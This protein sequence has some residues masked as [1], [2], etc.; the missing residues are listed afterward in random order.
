MAPVPANREAHFLTLP[1]PRPT[2]RPVFQEHHATHSQAVTMTTATTT[3]PSSRCSDKAT[4]TV[5]HNAVDLRELDAYFRAELGMS[6]RDAKWMAR[7]VYRDEATARTNLPSG[8]YA[9]IWP[10]PVTFIRRSTRPSDP[11]PRDAIRNLEGGDH[12]RGY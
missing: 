2:W 11:T 8:W 5:V 4:R 10:D 3:R 1:P 6:R 7:E 9:A 12:E